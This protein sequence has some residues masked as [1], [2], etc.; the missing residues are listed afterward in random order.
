MNG[1]G[2]RLAAEEAEANEK[3][4][5]LWKLVRPSDVKLT[6]ALWKDVEET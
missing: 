6:D 1:D 3:E 5:G 2:H 4:R